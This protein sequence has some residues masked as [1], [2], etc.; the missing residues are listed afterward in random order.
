[1]RVYEA[2][3]VISVGAVALWFV[4]WRTNA[5][6]MRRNMGRNLHVWTATA[7]P[8]VVAAVVVM[9]LALLGAENLAGGIG[10]RHLPTDHATAT[11]NLYFRH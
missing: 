3:A 1:M 6:G 11:Q 4:I 5:S 7:S 10:T 8:L 2:I 9:G